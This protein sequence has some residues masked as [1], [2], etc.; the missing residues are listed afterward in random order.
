MCILAL[1]G[2][3][4]K[5]VTSSSVTTFYNEEGEKISTRKSKASSKGLFV[6]SDTVNLQGE[7]TWT[8][9]VG[10]AYIAHETKKFSVDKVSYDPD[11]DAIKAGG[12]SV[13]GVIGEAAK[14]LAK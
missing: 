7:T 8:N 3:G 4:C 13:G 5:T 6:K 12:T 14:T 9:E 2:L 11:E 10:E 1:F